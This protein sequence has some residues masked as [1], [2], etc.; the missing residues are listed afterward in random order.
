MG[1]VLSSDWSLT[2]EDDKKKRLDECHYNSGRFDEQACKRHFKKAYAITYWMH[3]WEPQN[4]TSSQSE[5]ERSPN[6][7]S[8]DDG[9]LEEEQSRR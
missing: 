9:G 2:W 1:A 4:A 6:A 5:D 7:K 3:T 8:H